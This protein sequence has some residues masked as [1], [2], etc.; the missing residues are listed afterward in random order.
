M[1]I[2]DT[3]PPMAA[4][5]ISRSRR[6]KLRKPLVEALGLKPGMTLDLIPPER[7][8]GPWLLDTQPRAGRHLQAKSNNGRG[9]TY[10]FTMAHHLG[11]EHFLGCDGPTR[12]LCL[13]PELS[14]GL[15]TLTPA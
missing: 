12:T 5:V 3:T 4:A 7:R 8:G 11:A 10:F 9:W 14:P 2:L 13:G 6:V 15:Y 1:P